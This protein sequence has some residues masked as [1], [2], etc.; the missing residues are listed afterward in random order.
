MSVKAPKKRAAEASSFL[1]RSNILVVLP[2]TSANC[3]Q[4]DMPYCRRD[5]VESLP[6]KFHNWLMSSHNNV[7]A[8]L[9]RGRLFNYVNDAAPGYQ[10]AY[11]AGP[12][13]VWAYQLHLLIGGEGSLRFTSSTTFYEKITSDA[14]AVASAISKNFQFLFLCDEYRVGPNGRD[15]YIQMLD[16]CASKLVAQQ[17][18]IFPPLSLLYF[19]SE[20][21]TL[22]DPPLSHLMLPSVMVPV[23]RTFTLTARSAVHQ[24]NKKYPGHSLSFEDALVAKVSN[25]CGGAGVFFLDRNQDQ[26]GTITWIT[27]R[28]GT[29]LSDNIEEGTG[30]RIGESLKFE[31]YIQDLS[32]REWRFYSY[33]QHHSAEKGLTNIYGVLT[34]RD[35]SDGRIVIEKLPATY[36]HGYPT[37]L[38][39]ESVK[40][41]RHLF[42]S[43]IESLVAT[44]SPSWRGIRYLVF[45]F[46]CFVCNADGKTYL[47]EIDLFPIAHTMLDDYHSGED[48]I[49]QLANCTYNYLLEHSTTD[50]SW[51]M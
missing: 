35:P 26:V 43:A 20:K 34:S 13:A 22:R 24:L 25:S 17:V 16:F 4:F 31:P 8:L 47:N 33:L 1:S 19:L 42:K 39:R 23:Q 50:T 38:S 45:R 9:G 30:L 7:D 21:H 48:F 28:E 3:I 2:V 49:K 41:M 11:F 18:S 27:K 12:L 46:D 37:V 6:S 15:G 14:N 5:P 36:L 32:S 40:P 10:T 51:S 44:D 29:L